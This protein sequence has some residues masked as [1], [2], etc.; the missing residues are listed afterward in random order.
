MI[1]KLMLEDTAKSSEFAIDDND[2]Q[3]ADPHDGVD[4]KFK[5]S[6]LKNTKI[7]EES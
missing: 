6:I 3:S 4:D 1:T 2:D 7:M 5:K